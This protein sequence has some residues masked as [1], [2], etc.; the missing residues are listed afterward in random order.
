MD[1]QSHSFFTIKNQIISLKGDWIAL[2]AAQIVRGVSA[3][4]HA[5]ADVKIEAFGRG[6]DKLDTTGALILSKYFILQDQAEL[7]EG[8][9]RLLN[10]VNTNTQS[11]HP[12]FDKKTV[13]NFIIK[14][15]K[16]AEQ[17]YSY[18]YALVA[19]IGE[20][21]VKLFYSLLHP[22]KFRL[23]ETIRHIG[24]TGLA[25][26]PII[27][28]LAFLMSMVISYQ[29]ALQ[30]QQFG[31]DIY[32]VDLTVI[33]LLREMG[34]LITSIMV[35]GRSGSA[36]AAEIGVMK[37]RKEVDALRTMGINP[38]EVLVLPRLVALMITLPLLTFFANI[39]GMAGGALM[40]N[41]VLDIPFALYIDRAS[42]VITPML[43][44]VGMI[45]APVFALLIGGIC[46]FQ[47]M[48]VSGS[49]ENVGRLTT[50]AVVQS[51]FVV[52]LFDAIFSIIFAQMGV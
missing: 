36:F 37:L 38:I 34:V 50:V 1:S 6:I 22:Q 10:L 49:A 8:Q 30:L 4:L 42:G 52:I 20:F 28:L 26:L 48:S 39:I 19:F 3:V 41:V 51:I 15:G 31:A 9:I 7:R 32:T 45:K 27:G 35:A 14:I 17:F 43:I 23:A 44:F 13:R 33:S 25:A 21:F 46:A 2:N 47:G 40:A 18:L 29:G 11:D 12:V 16:K 5:T 24:E